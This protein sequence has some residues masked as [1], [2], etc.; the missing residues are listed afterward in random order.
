M[1]PFRARLACVRHA[2][3]VHSEPGS[4]SPI[5]VLISSHARASR[6]ASRYSGFAHEPE[7]PSRLALSRGPP[8][9]RAG[10][11][12]GIASFVSVQFSRNR[13]RLAAGGEPY[14]RSALESRTFSFFLPGS[15]IPVD[16]LALPGKIAPASAGLRNVSLP[17]R[18]VKWD[19][20]RKKNGTG[21]LAP[22]PASKEG[23]S[24]SKPGGPPV[25]RGSCPHR[26][27]PSRPSENPPPPVLSRFRKA[28]G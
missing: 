24:T 22:G 12:K 10:L 28:K 19:A 5:K 7:G 9:N 15:R 2:A 20:G 26:R 25:P 14:H 1:P 27:P 4:N 6:P 11:L 23:A 17:R 18:A 21:A 13:C 16:P 3:S 8:G